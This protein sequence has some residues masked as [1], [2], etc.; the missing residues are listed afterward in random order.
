MLE[1]LTLIWRLRNWVGFAVLSG[2]IVFLYA[3]NSG[4]RADI[5][6]E[7]AKNTVL[8]QKIETT[9][10]ILDDMA[11]HAKLREQKA[12]AALKEAE[13]A[14]KTHTVT[15]TRILMTKPKGDDQCAAAL[16]LLKEYQR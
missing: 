7:K 5:A 14:A 6:G 8:A 11:A 10:S 12:K 13:G 4:L 9:N 2:I 3:A 1:A 16:E 15:A